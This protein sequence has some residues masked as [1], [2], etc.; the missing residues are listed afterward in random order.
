[1]RETHT[2]NDTRLNKPLVPCL[3]LKKPLYLYVLE[4]EQTGCNCSENNS[5]ELTAT[6]KPQG[7]LKSVATCYT[8]RR[9]LDSRVAAVGLRSARVILMQHN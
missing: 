8:K 6:A 3:E 1:M 2:I 7:C 9:C 4:V 5:R